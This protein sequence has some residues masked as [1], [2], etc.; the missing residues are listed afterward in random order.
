MWTIG[1]ANVLGTI[2]RS[3]FAAN[4]HTG[5]LSNGLVVLGP[6]ELG[7]FADLA[8]LQGQEDVSS[9]LIHAGLNLFGA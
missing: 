2:S 9:L 5:A 7:G 3:A 8:S 6:D 4:S 1:S